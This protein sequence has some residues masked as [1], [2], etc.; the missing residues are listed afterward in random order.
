MLINDLKCA[1]MKDSPVFKIFLAAL[2]GTSLS[3]SNKIFN[4]AL[5]INRRVNTLE[6]ELNSRSTKENCSKLKEKISLI[7][8]RLTH[9]EESLK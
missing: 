6:I 2:L 1:L 4:W 8:Q 3:T 9:L 7:D 5:D